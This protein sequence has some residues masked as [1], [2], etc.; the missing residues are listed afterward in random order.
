[1]EEPSTP[2]RVLPVQ[3][4]PNGA[5]GRAGAVSVVVST[6]LSA[7][8]AAVRAAKT[9]RAF[10]TVAAFVDSSGVGHLAAVHEGPCHQ[11]AVGMAQFALAVGP[12]ILP[13]AG[14]ALAIGPAQYAEAVHLAIGP[15]TFEAVGGGGESE[16]P[17]R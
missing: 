11:G 3:T 5:A 17:R 7:S 2:I 9:A 8:L 4:L 16:C 12:V 13:V 10:V 14:I 1:M 15:D 6:I